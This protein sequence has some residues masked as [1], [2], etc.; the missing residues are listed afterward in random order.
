MKRY[1]QTDGPINLSGEM[2]YV[3][4]DVHK[5]AWD[6]TIQTEEVDL[7]SAGSDSF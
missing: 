7:S 3:G 4:I 1:A 5:V 2:V 6:V